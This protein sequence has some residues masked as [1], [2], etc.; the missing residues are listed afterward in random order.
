[1]AKP[2]LYLDILGTLL[3]ER[4]SG[5]DFAPFARTFIETVKRQFDVRLLSTMEEHHAI[6]VARALD[7]EPNY[8]TFRRALGK[9]SAINFSEIF[10]WV[11]DDPQPADLLRLS[12]ERCSDRL[13]PVSRRDGVTEA[14]LRK[15][16]ITLQEL[17]HPAP[18]KA[19]L[20]YEATIADT[21]TV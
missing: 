2:V 12:D 19:P 7:F 3:V 4:N 6:Q 16:L 17:Q 18:P 5:L 1:M 14:T 20:L 13:I 21:T 11:D 8:M 9:T 10:L 15:I